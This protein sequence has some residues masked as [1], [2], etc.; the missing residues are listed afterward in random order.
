MNVLTVFIMQKDRYPGHTYM[1][2]GHFSTPKQ[3]HTTMKKQK[4]KKIEY[5]LIIN[6]VCEQ[7]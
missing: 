2:Y 5:V 6:L 7:K 1:D 4:A 3:S